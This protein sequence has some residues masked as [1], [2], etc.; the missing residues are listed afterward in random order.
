[1]KQK[2]LNQVGVLLTCSILITFL[3][4][5]LV[6]YNRFNGYMMQGVRNE[7]EYIRIALENTSQDYLT[8]GVGQ[9]ASS[10]ITL[11]DKDGTVLFDS[12]EDAGDLENHSDRPEIVDAMEKGQG[13]AIRYSET[14][15]E[16][17]FYYAE[18]LSDGT[19]LRVARTTDSVFMTLQSS[20]TLLGILVIGIVV[21]AFFVIQRQT[22]KLIEPINQMDLAHPLRHVEYEELRPLLVR[23]HEQNRQIDHQLQEL[24]ANHEEYLAITEN[25]KDGLVI[26]NQTEGKR[27]YQVLANPVKIYGKTQG[28]VILIWDVT[29]KTEAEQMRREFSANVSHELKT[30]LMSISGY[31]ELI[32]NGMVQP[33]DI[34]EFA[35]RI[36]QEASRLT[37]LVEDI[38]QL[39][40]L[41]EKSSEMPYEWVDLRDLTRDIMQTLENV[42]KKRGV[43]IEMQGT[44]GEVYG[45]RH[46]LYEMLYNLTDNAI[47]YN[48]ENGWIHIRMSRKNGRK[49][50]EVSDGGIGI[51]KEDQDRIFERF[52]RVD[53]SH[54][55][56]TGGTGLG[57]SI[58]KH[59]AMMHQAEIRL[60]SQPGKGTS[61]TLDFPEQTKAAG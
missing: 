34:P 31:A 21:V 18:Q 37:N 51:A 5:S 24:K 19:I 56:E 4:V 49:L 43:S 41:D 53:K 7:A 30:P 61:I 1:M 44:C 15:A 26:T 2:I 8:E 22:T 10:R 3:A 29:E 14:L 16:Q 38:I 50:W 55:R 57:L 33:K 40:K 11:I 9:L 39:S 45:V 12:A 47:K 6:M 48:V 17:T 13:E 27:S 36:H 60:D 54:S 23:V 46:I 42:A 35:S 58:V 52:Y 59:G 20:I 32:Q 28:A 25:M